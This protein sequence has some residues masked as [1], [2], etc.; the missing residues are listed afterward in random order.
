[1]STG[2]RLRSTCLYKQADLSLC[3]V[4]R[5]SHIVT[6]SLPFV[7]IL[8]EQELGISYKIACALSED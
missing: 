4:K 6:Q 3:W 7:I 1:M 5:S 2:S 8:N